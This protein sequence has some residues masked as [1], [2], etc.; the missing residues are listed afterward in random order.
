[1][2]RHVMWRPTCT[3]ISVVRT[4]CSFTS[5]A[6]L[7]FPLAL[8]TPLWGW[9]DGELPPYTIT[10]PAAIGRHLESRFNER[11]I[12]LLEKLNRSDRRHLSSLARLVVP[13]DWTL[14]EIDYSP[15]P[16]RYDLKST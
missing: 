13:Q 16:A 3:Y 15:L 11:Q 7:T 8:I 5:K 1:M 14:D 2:R 12:A 6:L 9:T 10:S 4:R